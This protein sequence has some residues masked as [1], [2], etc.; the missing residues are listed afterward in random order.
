MTLFLF[1][2]IHIISAISW[3]AAMFYLGRIFVYHK[4]AIEANNEESA[5][6]IRQY[7]IMEW[8]VYR[9]IMT[10]AMVLTWLAGLTMVYIYGYEWFKLNLWLHH[11]IF[12]VLLLS[13]YH[14]LCK[15]K[16]LN[17][18]KEKLNSFQF[19][20]FNEVPTLFLILIIPIAVYKQQL[21]PTYFIL[22]IISFIG[23][24]TGLTYLYKKIRLNNDNG[25]Q[26][27]H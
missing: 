16:I 5:V 10:P 9:I 7:K 25:K 23:L 27:N 3:F 26:A 18:E 4:E 21:N 17:F 6:L 13:A 8:R 2:S 19:R 12:F 20:F 24:L 15:K 22:T 1:K 14:G 11:K